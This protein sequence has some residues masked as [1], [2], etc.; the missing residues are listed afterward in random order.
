MAT[1]TKLKEVDFIPIIRGMAKTA[2]LVNME[3]R[4]IRPALERD[5][6]RVRG[7]DFPSR[8]KLM[9]LKIVPI[10]IPFAIAFSWSKRKR[11]AMTTLDVIE[12][13]LILF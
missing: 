10:R 7:S 9:I 4:P 6:N 5:F 2:N 12:M 13:V 3:A 8:R 11:I 1:A